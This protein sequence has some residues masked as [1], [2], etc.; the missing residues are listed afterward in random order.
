MRTY[1][2]AYS[3]I[4][5]KYLFAS[6]GN[7]DILL[8]FINDVLVDS[9]FPRITEVKVTNPFN[10]STFKEEKYSIVDVKVVDEEG[11]K[12][13]IEVQ[14]V[15]ESYYNNRIL[16]YWSK[17]YSS[18]L[19][20][21]ESFALLRSVISINVLNYILIRENKN[22]HNLFG[23]Y[24]KDDTNIVL[25]DHIF[26]HFIEMPKL[27]KIKPNLYSDIE[28]WVYFFLNEGKEEDSNMKI[29]IKNDPVI[30]KAH[31]IY[32]KFTQDDELRELYENRIETERKILT[33]LE[34]AERKGRQEGERKKAIETAKKMKEKGL[35]MNFIV[36]I[37]GL[38]KEE[39]EKL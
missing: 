25:T 7:E 28:R 3:D 31:S 15:S 29:L 11:S 5:I 18:Q 30:K 10:I 33:E 24:M 13:N 26:F 21:G 14:S 20:K 6:E 35:D 1:V 19:K 34:T 32:D 2:K 37:T 16:Y 9:D 36:E 4:F 39:I 38:S 17:I 22:L 23:L 27:K 8:D 12:Y